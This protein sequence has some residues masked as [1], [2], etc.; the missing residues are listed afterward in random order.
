MTQKLD[1]RSRHYNVLKLIIDDFYEGGT[2]PDGE[3]YTF[4]RRTRRESSLSAGWRLIHW[5]E[6]M[7]LMTDKYLKSERE[8]KNC[9]LLDGAR[10]FFGNYDNAFRLMSLV[11]KYNLSLP[12]T[13]FVIREKNKSRIFIPNFSISCAKEG[14]LKKREN[15]DEF[16]NSDSYDL[17]RNLVQVFAANPDLSVP[18]VV[19]SQNFF[20]WVGKYGALARKILRRSMRFDPNLLYVEGVSPDKVLCTLGHKP[21]SDIAEE[22]Y[23][24]RHLEATVKS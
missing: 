2:K 1:T 18:H 8:G 20:N 9:G 12:E 22:Y 10:E 23:I 5:T 21:F 24:K 14:I 6:I 4:S 17:I 13:S 16:F 19:Q 7:G 3:I 15:I 11:E